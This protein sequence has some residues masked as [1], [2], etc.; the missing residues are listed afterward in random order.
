M[1][2]WNNRLGEP[3]KKRSAGNKWLRFRRGSRNKWTACYN[4][5]GVVDKDKFYRPR[6]KVNRFD[7][8]KLWLELTKDEA[9]TYKHD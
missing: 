1:F 3:N 9:K 2:G 4:K 8:N 7:R 6:N 5:K